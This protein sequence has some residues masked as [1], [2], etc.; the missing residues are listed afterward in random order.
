M[1]IVEV[2][3]ALGQPI[4]LQICR[5][6]GAGRFRKTTKTMWF[7]H[8]FWVFQE[9][10][11]IVRKW[12]KMAQHQTNMGPKLGTPCAPERCGADDSMICLDLSLNIVLELPGE[13][14]VTGRKSTQSIGGWCSLIWGWL[15]YPCSYLL[16]MD[17]IGH[18]PCFKLTER[19]RTTLQSF[20]AMNRSRY[21]REQARGIAAQVE[22]QETH[23][24]D[25][26]WP[27]PI[28]T[29]AS[30]GLGCDKN[31]LDFIRLQVGFAQAKAT[32]DRKQME[33]PGRSQN[34]QNEV[35]K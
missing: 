29:K 35:G 21:D 7:Y 14:M 6:Q 22:P 12:L 34:L 8:G 27:C 3:I 33:S 24:T 15:L 1:S 4:F 32:K 17:S 30:Y 18:R 9:L 5:Q 11:E 19:S 2:T 20:G 13:K 31:L 23:G 10:T 25:V 28:A 16:K 26:M